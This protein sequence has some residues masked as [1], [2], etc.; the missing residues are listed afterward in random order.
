MTILNSHIKEKLLRSAGIAMLISLSFFYIS[1]RFIDQ[2]LTAKVSFPENITYGINSIFSAILDQPFYISFNK[3]ALLLGLLAFLIIWLIWIKY[4]SFQSNYRTGEEQGSASWGNVKEGLVFKDTEN[5]FNNIVFSKTFGMKVDRLKPMFKLDRNWNNLVIGGSGSGKTFCW[6]QPNLM[7]LYGD[8]FLTDPK[9]DLLPEYGNFFVHNDYSVRSFNLWD[10]NQ[11]LH[12]NP[13]AYVKTDQDILKFVNCL[14]KNTTPSDSSKSDPFWEK[15]EQLLYIALI[16][17]LR[18]WMA[19][20]DYNLSSLITLLDMAEAKEE[21][22]N[23]MSPLDLLFKQIED[24]GKWVKKADKNTVSNIEA[25]SRKVKNTESRLE[26]VQSAYKHNSTGVRPADKGGLTVEED[27]SLNYYK[28][29]KVAAGKTLKSIIISCNVRLAPLAIREVRELLMYDEMQLNRLG[30]SDQKSIIFAILPDTDKTFSFLFAIM[31][32]QTI[33]LLCMKAL[34][35]YCKALPRHVQF[36]FDEFANIGTIPDIEETIAVVRS[37]NIGIDVILQSKS[38]LES[39]YDKHADTII[40]CCDSTIFLGGK[41]QTTTEEISKIIGKET[42]HTL[43]YG[44][45]K[46]GQD[47][48]SK[49]LQTSGRDLIDPAEIAKMDREQAVILISGSNP[50]KDDKYKAI[51]HPKYK[52]VKSCELFDFMSYWNKKKKLKNQEL[53]R[54]ARKR[55]EI[56]L[57]KKKDDNDACHSE[58]MDSDNINEKSI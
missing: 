32:W 56:S 39:R 52:D 24:G 46:G 2:I 47:S 40:D 45:S 3:M 9:G 8:Y 57:N 30:D 22:E 14:I 34:L 28:K 50:L 16:S 25:F 13:L 35:K 6:V 17:F 44:E 53:A 19:P 33:D 20:K 27:F 7:Q 36:I 21:N 12:Y 55:R 23:F 37:R 4:F 38:Q 49:N 29:F 43:S 11:S 48:S 54:D 31:M 26:W 58:S 42:I 18:D 51:W 15:S 5:E 1:N 10:M 41:S